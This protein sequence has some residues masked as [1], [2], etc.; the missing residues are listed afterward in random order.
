MAT[1]TADISNQPAEAFGEPAGQ[2][3]GDVQRA[4]FSPTLALTVTLGYAGFAVVMSLIMLAIE[5]KPLPFHGFGEQRQNAET[6]A[7]VAAF[8]VI[9]PLAVIA[10]PRLADAI[11]AGPNTAALSFLTA[12]LSSTLAA[13]VLLVRL[14][15]VFPWGDGVGTLLGAVGIWSIA[16]AAA[17]ARAAQ[18]RPWRSLLRFVDIASLTWALA[19]A[20]VLG[21]LL[22]TTDLGSISPLALAL[23]AVSIPVLLVVAERRRLPRLPGRWGVG[24]EV[25][26]ALMLLFAIPD[27]VIF[28]PGDTFN[29]WIIQF[30]HDY[31][32]GPANQILG[33]DA[34]LV[35]T[36]SQYGVGSIDFLAGWFKLTPIGYGTYGFLDGVLTALYFLAG[37]SVLRV[38]GS[39]RPLAASAVALGVVALVYNLVYSVGGLPQQ[40]P[41]RFGL[42]LALI[43]FVVASARWPRHARSAQAAALV[44]LAVSSIWALEAFAYTVAT[45]AAMACF[46]AYLLP[47]G[48]RL[49]WLGRQAVLAGAACACAHLLF[50]A[51][52]LA[53]TGHLPDWGQY[54]AYLHAYLFGDL[55]DFTYDFSRWSPGVAVGGAYFASAGA[56]VLLVRRQPEFVRREQIVLLALT[57]T[58]AY[59]IALFSYFVDRSLVSVLPYVSLP[60]L[61]AG[62]LWL[63][64]LVRSRESVPRG[65]RVGGLAFALSVAVLLLAIAW[66]SIGP[67]FERSALGHAL[68]GGNSL[69]GALDRLWHPP[70]LN[71]GAPEGERLLDRYMPGQR[72]SLVLADPELRT[73]ILMRSGR[74]DELPLGDPKEDSYVPSE[75]LPGLREAV[76][77]LQPGARL[78]LDRGA[79]DALAAIKANPSYDP[80]TEAL[81]SPGA[82]APVQQWAL[83]QIYERFR[84]RTLYQ[85]EQGFTVATLVPR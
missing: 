1:P 39:S 38:A 27:L 66:S 31:L 58:T 35:D 8:A 73:E 50:A 68:P 63:S 55:A 51:A 74:A 13:T 40:G 26:I 16:A 43:L 20:L 52:T 46:Q 30:H 64:L 32:L 10:G 25:L 61:L 47:P 22:A 67:R 3:S 81:T 49:R 37:Y 85:G 9:L 77:E 78:L 57:G 24:A 62:T 21:T 7:Y 29:N 2:P 33:G 28:S 56:L 75:R 79:L 18:G 15:G 83:Q 23:G 11:A 84:L 12:L 4:D 34:M 14:S 48:T 82:L 72:R 36:A 65:G 71:P 70:P 53:G 59:G 6:L 5:P 69:S 19:A 80:F 41:L 17:L 44:V 60:A 76:A 42:P 54:L 45:F